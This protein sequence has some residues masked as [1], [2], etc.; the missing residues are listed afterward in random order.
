RR[1]GPPTRGPP[2]HDRYPHRDRR[3]QLPRTDHPG[4]GPPHPPPGRSHSPRPT[5]Q[6]LTSEL[7]TFCQPSY[8]RCGDPVHPPVAQ[9]YGTSLAR[10]S[11]GEPGPPITP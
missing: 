10:R 3:L 2:G 1:A 5:D 9:T 8:T 7:V 4:H 6:V 11:K